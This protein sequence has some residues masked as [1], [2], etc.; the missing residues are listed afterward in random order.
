MGKHDHDRP[1]ASLDIFGIHENVVSQYG[2]YVA[3]FLKIGDDEIRRFV[4][5]ALFEERRLWPD[6]LLQLNPAYEKTTT[7]EA[8]AQS[9]V[10][11]PACGQ[12]F[13]DQEGQSFHLY[14]HQ[15]E[16]VR[17][18]VAGKSFVVTSGTGSG[19]TECFMVPLLDALVREAEAQREPLSGVRAIAL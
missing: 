12:I 7:V 5:H 18:G 10:L 1:S 4:E 2:Q 8:L 3:S 19:K 11:H 16:A 15:E 14:R 17:R 9:G 6:A 13:R